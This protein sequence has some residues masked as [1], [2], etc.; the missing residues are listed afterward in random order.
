MNKHNCKINN[1]YENFQGFLIKKFK[2]IKTTHRFLQSEQDSTQANKIPP[3]R[4]RFLP[5]EEDS[6]TRFPCD[7]S[8]P[9]YRSG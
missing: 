5:N 8:G 9:P 3:K 7:P 6:S 2:Y 4:K 1:V